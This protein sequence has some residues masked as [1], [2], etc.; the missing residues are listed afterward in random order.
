MSAIS[1]RADLDGLRAIA[2]IMAI[3]YHTGLGILPGGFI[4][5]EMFFVLS[6]YLITTQISN[7]MITDKF[8]LKEFYLRRFRRLLPTYIVVLLAT[9]I[10]AFFILLPKDFIYHTK[11]M[12]L[13]FMSLGNFYLANTTGGYFAQATEEI[14][15]LHTWSLSVEEQFYLLWPII[16]LFVIK[17]FSYT[18]TIKIF[19]VVL[20]LAIAMAEWLVRNNP[21]DAYFLLS[22]RFYE[23]LV[24]CM[25]ALIARY[26]PLLKSHQSIILAV[27]GFAGIFFNIFNIDAPLHFPGANALYAC[28]GTALIIY[29]GSTNNPVTL[30]ISNPVL[31]YIGKISYSLYLWH[32]PIFAL[33]RYVTGT[34]TPL[35]AIISIVLSVALSILTWKYIENP[36]RIRWKF[37]FKQT[38]IGMYLAPICLFII[39]AAVVSETEGLPQRFGSA[40]EAVATMESKPKAHRETC[41]NDIDE[42]CQ[43][44]LLMGDSHAEHFDPFIHV[45]TN[46]A[47]NLRLSSFSSPHCPPIKGLMRSSKTQS[48]GKN[49]V[50]LAR[51]E[52]L[53]SLIEKKQFQYVVMSAYWSVVEMKTDKIFFVDSDSTQ[54]STEDSYRVM[55]NNLYASLDIITKSQAIPVI[56]KDNLIISIESLKCSRQHFIWPGFSQNCNTPIAHLEQQQLKINQLFA[57][58]KRDFPQVIFIDP[59]KVLCNDTE[60]VKTLDNVPLYRDDDH[61]N[62][63]GS[64]IVGMKYLQ[65][66][67]NPL[68]PSKKSGQL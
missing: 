26:L 25:L 62:A 60:C 32:W 7:D 68:L 67:G 12:G 34:I 6:G 55:R 10:A 33:V 29:A 9:F 44:V 5:I 47:K 43:N 38:F 48:E 39:I 23:L 41:T 49:D 52:K 58:I 1:Y 22:S 59:N 42:N 11:L 64:H 17:R 66:F 3:I 30:V 50:C 37:P 8:S 61:F 54:A 51:N 19:F 28:L 18:N 40:Q 57:D 36:F 13:G 56:V 35:H 24:G 65:Q 31:T 27:I 15:L 45:F 20:V 4:G 21:T 63:T 2:I 14:T 16:L 46:D 53:Y